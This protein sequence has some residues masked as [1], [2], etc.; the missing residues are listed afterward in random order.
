M[1]YIDSRAQKFQNSTAN[2]VG[3][4]RFVLVKNQIFYLV[5]GSQFLNVHERQVLYFFVSIYSLDFKPGR[6]SDFSA[7]HIHLHLLVRATRRSHFIS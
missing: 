2:F 5:Q 7:M 4:I 1:G 6:N 3:N